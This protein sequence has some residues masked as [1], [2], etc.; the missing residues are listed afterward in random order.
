MTDLSGQLL[1]FDYSLV[2]PEII[3][4]LFAMIVVGA[5]AFKVQLKLPSQIALALTIVGI[6]CALVASLTIGLNHDG[7][8]AGL[9]ILDS[10]TT[11][12]RVLFY[13]VTLTIVLGSHEYLSLIHI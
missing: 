1:D 12:F 5:D 9:I 7:N 3:A 13:G 2:L 8:F 10:F 6:V 4:V 11:F